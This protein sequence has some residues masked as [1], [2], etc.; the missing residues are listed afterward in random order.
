MSANISFDLV[1]KWVDLAALF[2]TRPVDNHTSSAN[3]V[4]F[5][6]FD[7]NLLNIIFHLDPFKVTT[8]LSFGSKQVLYTRL[9]DMS[10]H[11]L[12]LQ[13]NY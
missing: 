5:I 6:P 11:V 1:P 2:L 10:C 9:H 13:P 4:L 3:S 12:P 7:M 8:T